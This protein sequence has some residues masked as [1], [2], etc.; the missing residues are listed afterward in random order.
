MKKLLILL[1]VIAFAFS[2]CKK[3]KCAAVNCYG[4]G[5]CN[6]QTGSCVCVN[7]YTGTNCTIAP[8]QCSV[9]NTGSVIINSSHTD[10][11]EIYI[12]GIYKGY[13]YYG[14]TTYSNIPAGSVS[15]SERQVN[16]VVF[17][18]TYSQVG[19]LSKCGTLTATF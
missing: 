14:T 3:E 8:S 12:N 15:I 16:Y 1:A 4:N 5:V 7:G 18:N 11:Y 6:E 2:S 9:N 13:Q 10:A 17:Q 19:T